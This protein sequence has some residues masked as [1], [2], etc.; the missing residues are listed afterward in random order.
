MTAL[1]ILF[2]ILW[3][4]TEIAFHDL[5]RPAPADPFRIDRWKESGDYHD[6]EG[7]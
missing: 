4:G 5:D 7:A 1:A 3:F 2:L 6:D